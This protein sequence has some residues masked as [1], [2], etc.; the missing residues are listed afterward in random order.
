MPDKETILIVD[1]EADMREI[2]KARLEALGF[3]AQTASG[4]PEALLKIKERIPDLVLLDIMMEGM[5]GIQVK[6]RLNQDETTE[7]LPV[8]FLSAKTH[9]QSKVQGLAVGADDYVTKPFDLEELDAR[10]KMALNR[11][12]YYEQVSM[13]DAL[14][15]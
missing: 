9:T 2:L 7:H 12:R 6:T 4:G 15:G 8:I 14:T 13:T 10:I 11:R 3:A 1:D 5:D